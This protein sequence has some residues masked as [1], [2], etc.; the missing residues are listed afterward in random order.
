MPYGR[1]GDSTGPSLVSLRHFGLP[2]QPEFIFGMEDGA[3]IRFLSAS[4]SHG[5]HCLPSME[6]YRSAPLAQGYPKSFST[7]KNFLTRVR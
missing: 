3:E 1:H 5:R 2:S 6:L 4:M 7:L